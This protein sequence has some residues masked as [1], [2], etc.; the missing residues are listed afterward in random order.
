MADILL[1]VAGSLAVVIVL[2]FCVFGVA[3]FFALKDM[4]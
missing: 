4:F 1:V 2:L 3:A